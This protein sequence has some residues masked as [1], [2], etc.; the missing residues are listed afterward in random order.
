MS[1][2]PRIYLTSPVFRQMAE[3][4]LVS[5]AKREKIESLFK[6]I[7]NQGELFESPVRFPSSDEIKKRASEQKT[8]IIGC[9]LSHSI[10]EEITALPHLRAVCTATAGYNH[11]ARHPGILVTHTPSVLQEAVADSIIALVLSSLKNIPGLNSFVFDKKWSCDD[12]W[13]MD[14][15]LGRSLSSMT[16]GIIGLGEIGEALARK[17][18]PWNMTILYTSRTRKQNI[19]AEL[20]GL[21]WCHSPSC[22][23]SAAD[24]VSL[25]VPLTPETRHMAGRDNLSLMKKGSLLVNTSRG[26]VVDMNAL[27]DM[28]DSGLITI[29]L[30]LDVFEPEPLPDSIVDRF[31]KIA[32]KNKNLRFIFMP[33]TSSA[34]ADTRAEMVIM[35][36]SDILAIASAL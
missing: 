13:D 10:A 25:N 33:H 27:L 32:G 9:H 14:A 30:A 5:S 11:I 31:N 28:L 18:A 36:L 8:E 12:K 34:D 4:H 23:F 1:P 29:N 22:I 26:E 16:L 24:I 15:F 6:T 19:E 3:N 2:R 17:L 20:P 7:E 35:M 21:V